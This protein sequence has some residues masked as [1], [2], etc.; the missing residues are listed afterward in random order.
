[1][2]KPD[3]EHGFAPLAPDE[4]QALS[5]ALA[6]AFRP[7]ELDPRRHERILEAALEDPLAPPSE[8][9]LVESARL[10]HALE[11]GE[12]HPDA[13]LAAALRAAVRG[14]DEGAAERAA[15]R[16][17]VAAERARRGPGR[18]G[19]PGGAASVVYAVF[20]GAGAAL[21]LAAAIALWLVPSGRRAPLEA[22][23]QHAST[24]ANGGDLA[25]SRSTAPLFEERFETAATTARIDRISAV[26]LREL[27]HNRYARW[28]VP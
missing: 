26:R 23:A 21:A 4:E 3:D 10:R 22:A 15:E 27:R 16:A 19:S 11:G 24:A 14:A 9:E 17:G 7:R 6:A 25:F 12:A 13:A 8:Q 1:M 5:E 20:G 18:G 2:T 28:G